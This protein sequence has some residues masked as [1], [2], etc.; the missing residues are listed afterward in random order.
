MLDGLIG[1]D[2]PFC[3]M[4]AKQ[5]YFIIKEKAKTLETIF[6]RKDI[7]MKRL[8][9]FKIIYYKKQQF[10]NSIYDL[11]VHSNFQDIL[12]KNYL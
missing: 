11:L 10:F 8:T 7:Q 9:H 1:S 12:R 3:D 2:R 6:N 4:M 5:K